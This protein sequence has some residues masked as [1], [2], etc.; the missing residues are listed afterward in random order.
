MIIGN[1]KKLVNNSDK[2]FNLVLLVV[3]AA[4]CFVWAV[5]ETLEVI[6]DYDRFGYITSILVLAACFGLS[7][8]AKKARLAR[9]VTFIY[10]T[11]YLLF[12]LIITFLQAA[13]T[14]N[15]YTMA[16]TLLWVPLIYVVSFLFLPNKQAIISAIAIY[17]LMLVLLFLAHADVFELNNTVLQALLLNA[18]LSQGVCIFCLFG[19]IK[20]KMTRDAS[21]LRAE[22]MER[23]ANID[24]LLGI[25]N[26]R[27]LQHQ[28]NTVVTGYSP[29]S[30]LLIDVDHF[31]DINDTHGHLVGDD[32]LRELTQCIQKSLRPQDTFGRWGGEEFLVIA[33]GTEL[34]S[35]ESLAQR[36]IDKVAK[37][38]FA[39]VGR[40]TVSIGVAQFYTGKS[41]SHTFANADK[42]LYEAK[43]MGR[44][45]VVTASLDLD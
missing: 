23:A 26:R 35:A 10:L 22:K 21:D 44:N 31:K 38:S 16:S 13:N 12:L 39:I 17:C 6:F 1:L 24:G 30:L 28:L 7:T 42:A 45:R 9:V 5:E 36:I 41:S 32:I 15:I 2:I 34:S 8:F 37:H 20:L 29:A 25:A 3:I 19:V 40:V 14:G 18:A 11:S 27:M 33:N 43:R 4:V